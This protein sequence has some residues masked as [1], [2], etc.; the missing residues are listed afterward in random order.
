MS[1]TGQRIYSLIKS[2]A[3]GRMPD[4][5]LAESKRAFSQIEAAHDLSV[6]TAIYGSLDAI[7]SARAKTCGCGP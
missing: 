1:W 4:A 7:R 5:V 3:A 2:G 6:G